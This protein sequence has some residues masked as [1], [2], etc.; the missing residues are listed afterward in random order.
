M[1]F[2]DCPNDIARAE[3]REQF[4]AIETVIDN[5][6]LE[7]HNAWSD[8]VITSEGSIPPGPDAAEWREELGVGRNVFFMSILML[9]A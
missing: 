8:A 9:N 7:A 1:A 5:L 2:P 4:V 3:H 6:I